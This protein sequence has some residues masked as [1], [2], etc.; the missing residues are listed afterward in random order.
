MFTLHNEYSYT[1]V[2]EFICT[3]EQPQLTQ[4]PT[5][6]TH[7]EHISHSANELRL[8]PSLDF[9]ELCWPLHCPS[10]HHRD[11]CLILLRTGLH[12][13]HCRLPSTSL[14]CAWCSLLPSRKMDTRCHPSAKIIKSNSIA[15]RTQ[16]SK[17]QRFESSNP[18]SPYGLGNSRIP[19]LHSMA[20][21]K[22][23]SPPFD[24]RIRCTGWGEGRPHAYWSTTCSL[25]VPWS[26]ST[27][28]RRLGV[29]AERQTKKGR[30]RGGEMEDMKRTGGPLCLFARPKPGSRAAH[31]R[32]VH[33]T[34]AKT[35]I[36]WV[37]D[38]SGILK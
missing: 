31:V 32:S 9:L 19:S 8:G 6:Y 29:R 35:L 5:L 16:Q 18:N 26:R 2:T 17:C 38:L 37:M 4:V 11:V 1:V 21:W 15:T 20:A 33:T 13:C 30:V 27:R 10:G 7:R 34:S 23:A 28:R 14:R 25:V 24:R 12:M 22:R 36:R 3:T